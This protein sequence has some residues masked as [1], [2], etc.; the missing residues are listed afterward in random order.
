MDITG[1][2]NCTTSTALQSPA[3]A[4][5]SLAVSGDRAIAGDATSASKQLVSIWLNAFRTARIDASLDS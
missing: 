1:L 5:A 2:P 3:N 4:F